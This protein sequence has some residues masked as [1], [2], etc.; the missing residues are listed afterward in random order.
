MCGVGA[1]FY[2]LSQLVSQLCDVCLKVKSQP[3]ADALHAI[4]LLINLRS[5]HYL[6]CAAIANSDAL[7]LV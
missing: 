1:I 2:L 3:V 6:A 5:N 4:S 7:G